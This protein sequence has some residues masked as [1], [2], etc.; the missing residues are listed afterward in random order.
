MGEVGR[1]FQ[2]DKVGG[3]GAL[4]IFR[5]ASEWDKGSRVGGCAK[6]GESGH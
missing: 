6:I 2:G 4:E 3:L 1:E 5:G